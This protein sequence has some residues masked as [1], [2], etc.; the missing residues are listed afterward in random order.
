MRTTRWMV[1]ALV[2]ALV[3]LLGWQVLTFASPDRPPT[4][5]PA[6]VVGDT[7]S[8]LPHPVASPTA[9]VPAP[10]ASETPAITATPI[11]TA[12]HVRVD[13]TRP[14]ARSTS[15]APVASATSKMSAVR[16]G[17]RPRETTSAVTNRMGDSARSRINSHHGTW[18][19]VK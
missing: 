8:P 11:A 6:I 17:P 2:A 1:A 10:S 16:P 12:A 18:S 3:I 9:A 7:P 15:N 14:R 5:E 13:P 19:V 4:S